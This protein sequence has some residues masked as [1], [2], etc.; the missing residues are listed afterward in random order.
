MKKITSILTALILCLLP[1]NLTAAGGAAEQPIRI[2]FIDSGISTRHIDPAHVAEGVNY[3]F[4][5]SDTQDR[6]GHGTAT[7]G[8]VL[9]AADQ[10][11]EGICPEAVAVPLVVMDAYPSGVVENGGTEALCQAILDAVELDCRIVNIS[12]S[13]A[14]DTPELRDAVAYAEAQGV[15]IVSAVGNDGEAGQTCYPAAYETV[16]AVG[17]AD[18]GIPAHFS[19]P[20]ADVLVEGVDLTA[21]TRRNSEKPAQ[22]SGTSYSCAQLAGLCA[23]LM[24]I[25]PDLTPAALRARLYGLA[26]DVLEPG[27]DAMSGWGVISAS[28]APFRDVR[29]DGWSY[30]GILY[31][32]THGLMNGVG[33]GLF[34]PDEPSTRAMLVTILWRLQGSPEAEGEMGFGDVAEGDWYTEAVRWAVANRIAEGYSQ[35]AFGP[36]DALTREQLALILFRFASRSG[37]DTAH[38]ARALT[39]FADAGEVSAWAADAMCWAFERGLITGIGENCLSPKTP[40]ARAQLATILMRYL[41]AQDR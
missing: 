6:I 39:G 10:G 41:E 3:V 18:G 28:L 22:V 32:Y 13:T 21:A 1:V 17:T 27:Y 36:S 19:Q 14:E 40:A 11:V 23:R 37:Q 24:Q 5:D 30:P 4:P 7:A 31:A 16:I 20:G 25:Y 15:V 35:E 38:D 2:A 34:A 29:P 9:G 12:L 26:E 8:M 33:D